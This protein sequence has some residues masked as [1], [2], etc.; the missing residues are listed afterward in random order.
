MVLPHEL[1]FQQIIQLPRLGPHTFADSLQSRWRARNRRREAFTYRQLE[2]KVLLAGDFKG[3]YRHVLYI[4]VIV[5]I[6]MHI[7]INI[8]T[9]LCIY[10][11]TNMYTVYI[12]IFICV[13]IYIHIHVLVLY[14]CIIYNVI[15]FIHN[16]I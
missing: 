3:M 15:I 5:Y 16:T 11:F 7:H 4:F 13:Y 8:F 9:F 1:N 12:Y 14:I 10:I 6:Y 2:L